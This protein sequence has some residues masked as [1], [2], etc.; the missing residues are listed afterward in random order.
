[1]CLSPPGCCG[2]CDTWGNLEN[3][4][5]LSHRRPIQEAGCPR[6]RPQWFRV[7][8]ETS[9]SFINGASSRRGGGCLI[10]T[11]ELC[12]VSCTRV[13]ISMY[14]FRGGHSIQSIVPC[15]EGYKRG[16]E[17]TRPSLLGWGCPHQ[18]NASL[19]SSSRIDLF[20]LFL[21]LWELLMHQNVDGALLVV[22]HPKRVQGVHFKENEVLKNGMGILLGS[23]KIINFCMPLRGKL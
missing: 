22:R 1:M 21:H 6:S 17:W 5:F 8:W 23:V 4:R 7:W 2:K 20:V 15:L 18:S 16:C 19:L 12:G 3:H 13:M 9:S 14:E 10:G 11:R